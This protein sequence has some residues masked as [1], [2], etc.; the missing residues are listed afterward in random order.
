[1]TCGSK[2][3]NFKPMWSDLEAAMLPVIK[4]GTVLIYYES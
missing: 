3:S 4:K 1:M 2:S